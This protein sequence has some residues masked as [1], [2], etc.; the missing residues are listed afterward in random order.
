VWSDAITPFAWSEAIVN[1]KFKAGHLRPLHSKIVRQCENRS[2]FERSPDESW[3]SNWSR[4]LPLYSDFRAINQH[5][6]EYVHMGSDLKCVVHR[7]Q[8]RRH[9]SW[10]GVTHSE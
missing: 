2:E 1:H 5:G 4:Y 8:R 9:E 3:V 10:I 7:G 6:E